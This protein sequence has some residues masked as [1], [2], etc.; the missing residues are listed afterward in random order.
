MV[1]LNEIHRVPEFVWGTGVLS[2]QASG[3][4]RERCPAIRPAHSGGGAVAAVD[5]AGASPGDSAQRIAAGDGPVGKCTNGHALHRSV[6]RSAAGAAPATAACQR[7]QAAGEVAQGIRSRQWPRPRAAP[8]GNPERH[9]GAPSGGGEL[10]GFCHR[11]FAERRPAPHDGE[12]LP[13]VGR[14]GDRSGARAARQGTLGC[15]DLTGWRIETMPELPETAF[16]TAKPD[17]VC[18]VLSRST[19]KLD[20]DEKLPMY[21]EHGVSHVWLVDPVA[22]ALEAY[23]LGD[24]GR[25]SEVQHYR[26]GDRV[27]IAPFDA[28]ELDLS[29]LWSSPRRA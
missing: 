4:A 9:R 24:A 29:L 13:D 16:F 3:A 25:W 12:L 6:G 22:Q 21:A 27:R 20:R 23:T 15:P 2:T 10:G 18:E 8:A 1:I 17:W 5:D 19:E 7:A 14:S 26:G 11:E 28:I